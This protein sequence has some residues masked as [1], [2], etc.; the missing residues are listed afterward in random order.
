MTASPARLAKSS[1]MSIPNAHSNLPSERT[2]QALADEAVDFTQVALKAHSQSK[3]G[4][5]N[6]LIYLVEPRGIEPLT[7]ALR[8]RRSPS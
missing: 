3:I 4:L 1:E 8:T 7:F 6:Y 2:K 5:P